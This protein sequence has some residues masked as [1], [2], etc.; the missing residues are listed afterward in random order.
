MSPEIE[1]LRG[2][3]DRLKDEHIYNHNLPCPAFSEYLSEAGRLLNRFVRNRAAGTPP[4]LENFEDAFVFENLQFNELEELLIRTDE[5]IGVLPLTFTNCSFNT[6]FTI[7]TTDA[8]P[9]RAPISFNGCNFYG[10]LYL[11]GNFTN[12]VS[13]NSNDTTT[14]EI[15]TH[16]KFIGGFES[17][18]ILSDV[19]LNATLD[20]QINQSRK[21]SMGLD[22]IGCHGDIQNLI[23]IQASDFKHLLIQKS[24]INICID[25]SNFPYCYLEETIA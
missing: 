5:I 4:A 18:I 15:H 22:I 8:K 7:Q 9:F 23:H 25:S 21:A 10:D 12:R 16:S 2:H 24:S 6:Q 11:L 17:G 14:C 13:F 3:I 1:K 19:L 20:V